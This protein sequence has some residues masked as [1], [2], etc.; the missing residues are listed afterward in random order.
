M[1]PTKLTSL[2]YA[3]AVVL[4]LGARAQSFTY[5]DF[6][7]A[8]L[9][10]NPL[11]I[12][13]NAAAPVTGVEGTPVLRLTPAQP[14]QAG[15]AFSQN[16]VQLGNNASFSTAFAFQLSSGGGSFNDGNQPPNPPGADGV[17]FVLNT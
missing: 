10:A 9:A 8:S 11:Q 13:G 7:S 12:N 1:K 14:N 15:S 17:V 4:P 2:L 6:S 5:N 16:T 3:A